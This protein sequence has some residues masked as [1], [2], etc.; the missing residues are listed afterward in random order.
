MDIC[1]YEDIDTPNAVEFDFFVFVIP[2]VTQFDEVRPSGVVLLVSC[3]GRSA[4][5]LLARRMLDII[6]SAKI[7]FLSRL[8]A[9]R[10][11]LSDSIQEL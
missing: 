2:I 5:D 4:T 3:A 9:S 6:P 7:V 10:N 8:A 11:P 1:F